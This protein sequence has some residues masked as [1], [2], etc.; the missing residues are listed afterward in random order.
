[1]DFGTADDDPVVPLGD[2]AQVRV[3]VRLR[4]R[5][6]RTVAFHVRLRHCHGEVAVPAIGVE[7]GDARRERLAEAL[8]KRLEGKEGVGPD[9]LHEHDERATLARRRLDQ[10]APREEVVRA[11][12]DREVAAVT[13]G[14]DR[15][16]A[17]PSV[18]GEREVEA[19]V[20]DGG[21]ED[22]VGDDIVDALA[23]VEDAPAVAEAGAI[24]VRRSEPGRGSR[25]RPRVAGAGGRLAAGGA[26]ARRRRT[27]RPDLAI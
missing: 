10:L 24:L 3:G 20:I 22:G 6:Q 23:A 18:L 15:E 1:V 11:P 17:E 8:R 16:L 26:H 2:D 19:R 5:R 14:S 25:V 13:L 21:P 9:L 4:A 12:G 7:I 27:G